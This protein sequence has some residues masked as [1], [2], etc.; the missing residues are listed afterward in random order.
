MIPV[1]T[2]DD[3]ITFGSNLSFLADALRRR[4]EGYQYNIDI[5]NSI[6]ATLK[7]GGF[8]VVKY[9]LTSKVSEYLVLIYKKS[10][11]DHQFR[12][13]YYLFN[14][15]RREEVP[16][17][18]F[19]FE[20]DPRLCFSVDS[21][22]R[23]KAPIP[24]EKLLLLYPH[25]RLLIFAPPEAVLHP[26]E[27]NFNTWVKDSLFEW[28]ERIWV[29]SIPRKNWGFGEFIL[30]KKFVLLSTDLSSQF[31]LI[32][33]LKN[34]KIENLEYNKTI[35]YELESWGEFEQSLLHH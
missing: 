32:E 27:A 10:S 16:I 14:S 15:L 6:D 9:Y 1:P 30:Q 18:I 29:S 17:E 22:E 13:F 33:L 3:Q 34:E 31:Q 4:A 7:A 25:H 35:N 12:T 26:F 8:P 19:F 20:R 24:I 28:K 23:S 2:P 5:P 21:L 11:Q